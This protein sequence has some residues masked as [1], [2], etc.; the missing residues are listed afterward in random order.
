MK[1]Q[2]DC[3]Y[4]LFELHRVPKPV[5]FLD[6]DGTLV[7]IFPDPEL[8]VA[9]DDLKNLLGE[10]DRRFE[11]YVVT[12]RALED[13]RN[14]IGI[15]VNII[16]LHGAVGIIG[17]KYEVYV[18]DLERYIDLCNVLEK[19]SQIM[20]E[21]YPGLRIYNKRGNLL[22]HFGRVS[23]SLHDR[24]F[25]EVR[26]LGSVHGLSVYRGKLIIELR[27]PGMDKGKTISFLRKGRNSIIAGDDTTD[28]EAFSGNPDAIKISVGR[29]LAGS[30]CVLR[31]P[32]EMRRFLRYLVQSEE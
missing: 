29:A 15:K 10:L 18:E 6:Y 12:G 16:A 32:D 23:P 3:P 13:I 8:A 19:E 17:G 30:D 21:R 14:L 2:A 20:I 9:D 31:G 22:F 5:L 7:K 28:E 24:L 26:E 4:L 11:M 1:T 25:G 27:I